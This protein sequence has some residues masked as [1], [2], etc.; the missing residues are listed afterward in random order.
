MLPKPLSHPCLD[1]VGGSPG[2][3][4]T[5]SGAKGGG[6]LDT[7]CGHRGKFPTG[8]T[9]PGSGCEADLAGTVQGEARTTPGR[10]RALV[11]MPPRG[12]TSEALRATS[13]LKVLPAGPEPAGGT[14]VRNLIS[15][16]H[17]KC[18]LSPGQEQGASS[19]P[20]AQHPP[21]AAWTTEAWRWLDVLGKVLLP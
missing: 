6:S 8:Q 9:P 15:G 2:C 19:E 14:L 16:C 10:A 11:W 20:V 1:V 12:E 13:R 21:P 17:N 7:I 5:V 3:Q 4:R 18:P